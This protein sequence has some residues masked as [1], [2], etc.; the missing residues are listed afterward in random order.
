M[1]WAAADEDCGRARLRA[2]KASAVQINA[3]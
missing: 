3:A 2:G 1:F